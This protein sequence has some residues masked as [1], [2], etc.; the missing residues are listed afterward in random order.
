[1]KE[2]PILFS[3]QMVKAILSGEKTQTRRIAKVTESG[4]LPGFITPSG[5]HVPRRIAEHISY[6]PYG[7]IGDRLWVR[8]AWNIRDYCSGE[9][10]GQG[11]AGYP[12]EKIP[13]E[14]PAGGY[15][16]EF[17]ADGG[18]GPWRPSIHMPRWASRITLEI[19]DVRV[20][21]L[22]NISDEDAISEGVGGDLSITPCYAVSRFRKLWDSI[23]GKREGCAWA[24]NPYVWAV[25]FKVVK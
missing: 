10:G 5:C 3:G 1:M 7:K 9:Y 15:C 17:A 13:K 18:D 8:E 14:R 2:S 23:N 11:E 12:F 6:C 24:D 21:R 19:T 16:L 20:E 25:S 4:C 22:Q